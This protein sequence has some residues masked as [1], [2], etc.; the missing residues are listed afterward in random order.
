MGNPLGL[1]LGLVVAVAGV[2]ACGTSTCMLALVRV[3]VYLR[4]CWR[5][6]RCVPRVRLCVAGAC[7][8]VCLR[9]AVCVCEWCLRRCVRES[10]YARDS[11]SLPSACVC[12]FCADD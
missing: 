3:R 2:R 5:L 10:V 6:V 7:A 11:T 12:A 8:C 9:E 1:L 4:V